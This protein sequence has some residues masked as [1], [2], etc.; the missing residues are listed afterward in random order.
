MNLLFVDEENTWA[1]T[2]AKVYRLF[3]HSTESFGIFVHS[4][5]DEKE[6]N[7]HMGWA[8][9]AICFSQKVAQAL[10]HMRVY[11]KKVIIVPFEYKYSKDDS[12]LIKLFLET[13]LLKQFRT[14]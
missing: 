4:Y 12:W 14:E 5:I 2:G 10:C 11:W 1:Q 13:P 9:F 7:Q 3:K 8:D 6:V